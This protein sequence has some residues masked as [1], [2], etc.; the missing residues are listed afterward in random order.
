MKVRKQRYIFTWI[1]LTSV[2][3]AATFLLLRSS[4]DTM[5]PAVRLLSS[6]IA[7][8]LIV[9][10]AIFLFISGSGGSL[11][12][13]AGTM[14]KAQ[15]VAASQGGEPMEAHERKSLDIKL[16]AGKI[17]RRID[18]HQPPDIWGRQLIDMLVSELEIMTAIFYSRDQDG[19]FTSLATYA[20]QG[21]TGPIRF[22]EGEGLNGQAA[23]NGQVQVIRTIP[24]EYAE[25]FSGL[26]SGK[27]AYIAL[28][29][30]VDG[31]QSIALLEV[32]GYRWADDPLEQL[33]HIIARDITEK[34]GSSTEIFIKGKERSDKR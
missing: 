21:S 5:D 19:Q 2:I 26:G 14:S 18:L 24:D 16:V 9:V 3:I 23:R 10:P 20:T 34:A 31:D 22:N 8:F 15:P 33:F 28:I 29:P 7:W 6:F 30:I 17:T 12:Q 11:E 32:A 27:P 25:V 13:M 1:A 4:F